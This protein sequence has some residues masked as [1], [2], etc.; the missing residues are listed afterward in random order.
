M[1]IVQM[2]RAHLFV[3]VH[4]KR[5]DLLDSAFVLLAVSWTR[6]FVRLII[7]GIFNDRSN[8]GEKL[9]RRSHDDRGEKDVNKISLRCSTREVL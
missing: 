7:R 5:L 3:A 8:G 9:A 2:R 4:T 6:S 1:I